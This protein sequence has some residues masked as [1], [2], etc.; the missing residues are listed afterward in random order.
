MKDN[1]KYQNYNY[2]KVNYCSKENVTYYTIDISILPK[3]IIFDRSCLALL[4][5]PWCCIYFKGKDN[6]LLNT[7]G[8]NNNGV[9]KK[10]L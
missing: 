5:A 10:I 4:S 9:N 2:I 6:L 8:K 1:L 7:I 3:Q